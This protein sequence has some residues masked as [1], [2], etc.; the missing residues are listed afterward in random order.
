[1]VTEAGLSCACGLGLGHLPGPVPWGTGL[2]SAVSVAGGAQGG[3]L[4]ERLGERLGDRGGLGRGGGTVW[5]EGVGRKVGDR[6]P[7][8]RVAGSG[9]TS[10]GRVCGG[11][12]RTESSG[13]G[14]WRGAS[15]R[16][17]KEGESRGS[18]EACALGGEVARP[19]ACAGVWR[20]P[21]A[22]GMGL[23]T[24]ASFCLA[25]KCLSEAGAD[26]TDAEARVCSREGDRAG[27]GTGEEL[28][29]DCKGCS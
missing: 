26:V 21:S 17:R 23:G 6:S 22:G 13:P 9:L 14:L 1:M 18:E 8:E 3:R 10:K 19:A 7:G 15:G 20:H 27:L 11:G 5:P 24:V 29:G 12:G 4:G 16:A 28:E 2:G 25:G